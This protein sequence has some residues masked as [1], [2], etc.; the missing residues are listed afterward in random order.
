MQSYLTNAYGFSSWAPIV[1]WRVAMYRVLLGITVIL[2]IFFV[3]KA[4]R[5]SSQTPRE[6]GSD[7][8]TGRAPESFAASFRKGLVKLEERYPVVKTFRFAIAGVVGFGVTEMVLTIGLL[9]FYGMVSL[10][11]ASFA[12]PG[13]LGLDILSLLIGV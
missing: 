8:S 3:R 4:T 13:L 11:Y 5:G 2:F 12:S 7:A 10:S 6:A 9:G 1:L